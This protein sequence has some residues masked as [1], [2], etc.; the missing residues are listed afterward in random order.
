MR[1]RCLKFICWSCL[2][3]VASS[4]NPNNHYG[5]CRRTR[6]DSSRVD[7]RDNVSNLERQTTIVLKL[8][9]SDS[10]SNYRLRGA[11]YDSTTNNLR[12]EDRRRKGLGY[13]LPI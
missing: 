5:R 2:V 6:A 9:Y 12:I 7:S 13:D 3:V 11:A 4:S 1:K 8:S 10:L